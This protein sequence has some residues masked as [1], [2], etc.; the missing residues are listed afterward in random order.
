MDLKTVRV[1]LKMKQL[2]AEAESVVSRFFTGMAHDPS[3]GTI[4]IN[5]ERYLLVRAA[6]LSVEF[7][8]L[9]RNLFGAGKEAQADEFARN[10]LF[11]LAH[12]IGKSDARNFHAK[13]RLDDPIARL[14]AGPVHFAHAG[15][16][17]VD[18]SADSHPT[19]DEEYYLIYDH[20]YSFEAHA[21]IDRQRKT[22]SPVCVMNAGYAAGWCEESFGVSLAA[23][24]ILCRARGDQHCRFIMAPPER[25][26]D[27]V[28]R[29]LRDR[30]D[31]AP[32][33]ESYAIPELFARKRM[34]EELRA[35]EDQY[36]SIFEAATDGFLVLD[37]SGVI[38]DANP[39][40]NALFGFAPG[41]MIGVGITDVIRSEDGG[42]LDDF[43]RQVG[44][45][46]QF[47]AELFGVRS[48]G[49]TLEVEVRGSSF[50]S[51]GSP[52][53]LAVVRDI[54]QRKR[55][56]NELQK[57]ASIVRYSSELV[58]LA[59]LDGS[60]IFLNEAG[61][62]MLGIPCE[63]VEQYQIFDVLPDPVRRIAEREILPALSRGDTWKG[64]LQYRNVKTGRCTDVHAM[65]F[66]IRDIH[67]GMP[68]YLANVSMDITDRK[69]AEEELRQAK[70]AAEAANRAKSDFL[71]NMSHEIRTPMTAV[72]GF[73]DML[74]DD[75]QEPK[76][77]EAI[78]TVKR[79]GEH[80]LKVIDDILDLSK[81][82]AGKCEMEPSDC[83][84]WQIVEEVVSLNRVQAQAKGLSLRA[85]YEYP[86]P[87]TIHTDPVRL[88][89]ALINLVGNAV[90][91]TEQGSVRVDVRWCQH[92][93]S[94]HCIQFAVTDT[95]IGIA[96]EQ[97]RE[98]FKPF[99]QADTTAS[100]RFGG[101]GL[102]L[103]ITKRLAKML[104]GDVEV[105]SAPYE[106]STFTLTISAGSCDG[107]PMLDQPPK[108]VVEEKRLA[109]RGEPHTLCGR[110]LLAEDLLDNQRLIALLLSKAGLEVDL[111][112]NGQIAFEKAIGSESRG[113][114]YDLILMDMQ[115]PELD[116]YAATRKLRAHGWQGPIVALTAHAMGGD[117]EKC[118]K[119]GCTEYASKPI[120]R[121]RLL[122]VAARNL[123]RS[124]QSARAG[125][126]APR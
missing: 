101:T 44:Q 47:C 122:S 56:E 35:R 45:G 90:K 67:S 63:D 12:A 95:G 39:S 13:M 48:D 46:G 28:E 51:T 124:R 4:E 27:H 10:I 18:I 68:L 117:R 17:S 94:G 81:I 105:R 113:E 43:K 80:L 72:M 121:D 20:P 60:M 58:N 73:A 9:V 86:L 111:A 103:T 23:T 107:V 32:P 6:S 70:E 16:A 114:P 69:L 3:K 5:G 93:E 29:Y 74:L 99:A 65:T 76:N 33:A 21:W 36:R 126:K 55:A 64:D 87:Q 66:S 22:D 96:E 37:T 31:L 125:G 92:S 116:G 123:A 120:D 75:L 104:D 108:A 82:E 100:R 84:P 34:E 15:W 1:P 2:F 38:V 77:I 79:N 41:E 88:R 78:T 25:I 83:S 91:F 98:V 7:F 42:F 97:I 50:H 30:P 61:S 102:G 54:D 14:S 11:D 119:A 57:L 112:E 106:G 49:S 85:E 19:P 89:Q 53:L 109:E 8:D 59:T 115:M 24:E 52:H 40:A 26:A 62:Q 71:A 110:V 118:L